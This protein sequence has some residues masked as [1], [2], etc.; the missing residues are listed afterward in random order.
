MPDQPWIVYYSPDSVMVLNT[1]LGG[2]QIRPLTYWDPFVA[3]FS[4]TA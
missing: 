4:A 3:D 2:Y 1:R